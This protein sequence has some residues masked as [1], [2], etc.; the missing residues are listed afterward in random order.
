MFINHLPAGQDTSDFSSENASGSTSQAANL[1]EAVESG[2]GLLL[3][4]EDT[5]ATNF[6]IR[7]KNMRRIIQHDPIIP[8]TDGIR[9]LSSEMEVSTI[10]VIG[11]SSEYLS[12][13]D[14]VILIDKYIS[15]NITK[16]ISGML[17]LSSAIEEEI[18]ARWQKSRCLLPCQ[19]SRR[20]WS[21]KMWRWHTKSRRC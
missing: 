14:N 9:E 18:P 7:D 19:N 4:D 12:Y 13:A 10:L 5:S 6:M 20:Y 17:A 15:K 16:D 1:I 2:A 11:G 3:L 21:F 8:F